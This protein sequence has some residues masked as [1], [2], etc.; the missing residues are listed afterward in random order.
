LENQL[1]AVEGEAARITTAW[2]QQAKSGNTL[3][4]SDADRESMS[5]FLVLQILRTAEARTQLIQLDN[6]I[7][8]VS[9]L[10]SNQNSRPAAAQLHADLMWDDELITAL[11]AAVKGFIW[12]LAKNTS[13]RRLYTSD[14]PIHCKTPD[15]KQWVL[16]PRLFD[17]GIYIVFPLTPAVV[18]YCKERDYWRKLEKF[19]GSVSPVELTEHMVDHE[20]SGQVGMSTR[21]VFADRPDFE[22]A[23]MFCEL[24]PEIRDPARERHY[25]S[26]ESPEGGEQE[27]PGNSRHASP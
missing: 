3:D 13:S 21:F 11:S 9:P 19:D 16:G 22:F 24:H 2:L 27:A 4:I 15:S 12:V 25:W 7:R 18:L 10:S 14:H 26:V 5:L 17:R 20:N 6:A 8:N 23:K 1:S